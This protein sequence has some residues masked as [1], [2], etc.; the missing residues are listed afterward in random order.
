MQNIGFRVRTEID[1]PEPDV[2]A[3]L[4]EMMSV[5][6]SDAM[7]RAYTMAGLHPAYLPLG[8]IAGPA[9][10]VSLPVGGINMLKMAMELTQAGDVLVVDVRG[11]TSAAMWGGNVSLGMRS[12]GVR[13]V[14]VDG[15]IRDVS[16]LRE[17]GF[18]A[19]SRGVA[20]PAQ[21]SSSPRGEIN[22]PIA[23]GG[24]VVNP[25][26]IVVADE[27]GIVVVAPSAADEVLDKAKKVAA[28]LA[29]WEPELSQG[30]IPDIDTIRKE[31]EANGA[32]FDGPST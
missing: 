5:D 13:G 18:P 22:V 6:L 32:V 30:R 14:I 3:R 11:D 8:R 7:N 21:N 4:G 1:R 28:K 24:V 31:I 9:V 29:S 12:R 19:W 27:D 25:G 10:T 15:A 17:L 20:A 2:V 23:C 16:Q 26:D